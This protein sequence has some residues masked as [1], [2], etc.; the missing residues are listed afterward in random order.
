MSTFVLDLWHTKHALLDA[1]ATVLKLY[2]FGNGGF[3][4]MVYDM[5]ERM[6]MRGMSPELIDPHSIRDIS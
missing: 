3:A 1:S 6:A 2:S 4:I 5:P